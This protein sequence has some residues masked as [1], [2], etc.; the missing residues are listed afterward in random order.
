MKKH[1]PVLSGAR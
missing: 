1:F